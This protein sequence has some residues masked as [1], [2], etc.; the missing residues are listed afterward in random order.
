MAENIPPAINPNKNRLEELNR[1][2]R[3]FKDRKLTL[4]I[5]RGKPGP[6]QL[7]LSLGL[8]DCIGPNGY[9]AA[10][11]TDCRNY[12]GIDGLPEAKQLFGEY[13]G[14]TPGNSLWGAT[15]V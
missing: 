9:K 2:C 14:V 1:R 7:D 12:G 5:T 11:G 3:I 8:L 13:M 10:D 4:D 15:P 6:E